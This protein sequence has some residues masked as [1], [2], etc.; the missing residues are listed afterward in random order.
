MIKKQFLPYLLGI[1][2]ICISFT[3]TAH[4]SQSAYDKDKQ[5][6]LSGTVKEFRWAN[7][8]VWLY[9]M[10]PDGKGGETEWSLEGGSISVLARNG[11]RAKTLQ[12]GDHV[13]VFV[14]PNKDGSPGGG[15]LTVT[16]DDGSTYTIGVI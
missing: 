7:P 12:P 9:V 2:A 4:H 5:I 10:V 8:H 14:N 11:W 6:I 16:L 15:F 3:A 13:R 1:L